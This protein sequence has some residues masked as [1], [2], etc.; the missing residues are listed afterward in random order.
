[1]QTRDKHYIQTLVYFIY[2]EVR[3]YVEDWRSILMQNVLPSSQ[4]INSDY[5]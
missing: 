2:D 1:M 5:I 4:V 3:K